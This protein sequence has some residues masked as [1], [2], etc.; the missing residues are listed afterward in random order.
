MAS[1]DVPGAA[2]S[3]AT[4]ATPTAGTAGSQLGASAG[5]TAREAYGAAE[6]TAEYKERM[7]ACNVWRAQRK[8]S[9]PDWPCGFCGLSFPAEGYGVDRH[10]TTR[11]HEG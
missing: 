3:P 6:A 2:Q 8:Q 9:G 4:P 5:R 1:Q 10:D 7:A 11:L